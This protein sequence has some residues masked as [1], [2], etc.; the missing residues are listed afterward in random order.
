MI[1]IYKITN[2]INN[3]CYI[4]QSTDI[5][6]RWSA[7]K[8]RAF[9]SDDDAYNTLLSRAFRKYGIEAFKFEVLEECSKEHLDEREKYFIAKFKSNNIDFG[10]NLTSGG[11]GAPNL[12]FKLTNQDVATIKQLLKE[13]NIP[14]KEIA[15]Q[16]NVGEDTI[17]MINTGRTRFSNEDNYPIRETKKS[18]C[19]ICGKKISSVS[20]YC[21]KCSHFLQRKVN[22]PTRDE[23]KQLIWTKAFTTIGKEF[24]VSDN[25]IRK[26][27]AAYNLPTTKKEIKSYSEQEWFNI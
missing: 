1:G 6:K 9:N 27:C 17:S 5:T 4:G 11:Q 16:F 2:L 22:R 15:I 12:N 25:T 7:E 14:Q 20:T 19:K 13:T 26:W 3:K 21:N 24:S 10:Y 18:Y 8:R 23:L